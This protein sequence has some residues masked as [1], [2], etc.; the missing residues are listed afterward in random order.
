ML[1][2]CGTV[3]TKNHNELTKLFRICK[4]QHGLFFEVMDLDMNLESACR[5]SYA[6][7]SNKPVLI[8][9]RIVK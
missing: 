9:T 1:R 4:A 5:N 8:I 7:Y 6:E 2:G 3:C